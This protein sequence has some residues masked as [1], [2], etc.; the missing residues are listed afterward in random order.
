MNGY[1]S[2]DDFKANLN[3]S[4]KGSNLL[5]F[6]NRIKDGK[7]NF[8]GKDYQLNMNFPH[9]SNAIHG[10]IFDIPF[11]VTDKKAEEA[12]CSLKLEYSSRPFPGYPFHYLV[13][14]VYTLRENSGFECKVKINNLLPHAM[15]VGH[16]WHPYFMADSGKVDDLFLQF[17]AD[18]IL[19]VDKT[20]IPTG[21]KQPYNSFNK[22]KK[23]GDTKLDSCFQ[24]SR[25]KDRAEIIIHNKEN[26]FGYCIWQETGQF[27]YNF[28]QIYTPPDRKSVAIEPMTCAPD[29]FNNNNGLIILGPLEKM[30]TSFGISAI[31]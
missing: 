1:T 21:K 27:K 14:I 20:N 4:F 18:A 5:P 12:S 15:P 3:S 11:K 26:G 7:Y 30:Q 31:K 25:D 29:A 13:K 23:I 28:L 17:P 8:Q 24:L 2:E 9:E 19:E 22:L 10:L 6:P 16:G